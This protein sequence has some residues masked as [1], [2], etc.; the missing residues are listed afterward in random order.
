MLY[1]PFT[2]PSRIGS[3]VALI[4]HSFFLECAPRLAEVFVFYLFG[5]V[6]LHFLVAT[7]DVMMLSESS[8]GPILEMR[9]VRI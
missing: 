2:I 8:R 3:A 7:V 9:N 6:L 4:M 5:Q 1:S